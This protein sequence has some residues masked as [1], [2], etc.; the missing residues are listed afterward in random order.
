MD[1]WKSSMDD[2]HGRLQLT[3][4]MDDFIV[5]ERLRWSSVVLLSMYIVPSW[6][7]LV[8]TVL[9]ALN[10]AFG[11]TRVGLFFL[12]PNQHSLVFT[13]YNKCNL[14]NL[15][16]LFFHSRKALQKSTGTSPSIP[17]WR[18]T[19]PNAFWSAGIGWP[20]SSASKS[21]GIGHI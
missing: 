18:K 6:G 17:S 15:I 21:V 2:L 12:L 4:S 1:M 7:F 10:D 14:Q 5:P 13:V 9:L 20:Y 11:R 19:Y 16:L 8:Q 3:T